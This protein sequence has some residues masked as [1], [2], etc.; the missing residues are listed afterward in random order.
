MRLSI[1]L[2]FI[3][4]IF[5]RCYRD[6]ID[7]STEIIIEEVP[8]TTGGTD[9][10]GQFIDTD[11]GDQL[12][13]FSLL[14][15]EKTYE[16]PTAYF[17]LKDVLVNKKGQLIEIMKDGELHGVAY[18]YLLEN[19]MNRL[20]LTSFAKSVTTPLIGASQRIEGV[21]YDL[22][23]TLSVD[24]LAGEGEASIVS[25][26]IAEEYLAESLGNSAYTSGGDLL[27]LNPLMGFYLSFYR[28]GSS[29]ALSN[30]TSYQLTTDS[31]PST[32]LFRYDADFEYWLQVEDINGVADLDDTGYFMIAEY[33][34]GFYQEG[35]TVAGTT[36]ISYLK[37]VI[38]HSDNIFFTTQL[39]RWATVCPLSDE[40]EMRFY[41]ECDELIGEA[42]ISTSAT[43]AETEIRLEGDVN[44]IHLEAEILECEAEAIDASGIQLESN[45][46]TELYLFS[47]PIVN[48]WVTA[49]DTQVQ[50]SAYDLT[51]NQYGPSIEWTNMPNDN[52]SYLS[53]C[54]D[55]QDGFSYIK[56]KGEDQVFQPFDVIQDGD[57]T[58]LKEQGDRLRFTFSGM[59]AGEYSAEDVLVYINHDGFGPN[60]YLMECEKTDVGCGMT[61]FNVTHFDQGGDGWLRVSFSGEL[62]MRTIINPIADYY[63]IEGVVMT[64]I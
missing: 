37:S 60:G 42:K 28:G 52:L 30:N 47:E 35:T 41:N 64:R 44:L 45:S 27:V 6:N 26:F 51:A 33:E 4:L 31:N 59:T 57:K 54:D 40:N 3:S 34:S 10:S 1:F 15:N 63:P 24:Q 50:L 9:L 55:Y 61:N 23:F 11:T 21:G 20:A 38:E 7:N 48:A 62:W 19:D 36:T 46:E 2:I 14:I 12:S 43:N 22:A 18:P 17:F 25:H 13:G 58:I 39:G 49:C 53:A 5:C 32:A 29:V 16:V 56:I 8:T